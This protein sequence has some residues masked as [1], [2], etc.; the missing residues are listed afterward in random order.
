MDRGIRPG[1]GVRCAVRWLAAARSPSRPLR[2]SGGAA[3]SSTMPERMA[4]A[5]GPER[6]DPGQ[7]I[8]P[9]RRAAERESDELSAAADILPR[10]RPAE[11][12]REFGDPTV[13]RIVAIVAHQPEV[14]RRNN[15][16][17]EI[18]LARPAK[19]DR[20]EAAPVRQS[21]ANDGHSAER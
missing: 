20:V 18:I 1:P 19:L 7:R 11:P 13:G 15:D 3:S 9:N 10:H 16:R 2:L 14:A 4:G 12:A 6:R 21:L 17:E 5:A 8:V